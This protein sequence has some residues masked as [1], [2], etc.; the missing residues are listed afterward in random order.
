MDRK[1]SWPC[2]SSSE[3]SGSKVV[4]TILVGNIGV[5]VVIVSGLGTLGHWRDHAGW[6]P[7]Q[8]GQEAWAGSTLGH[9]FGGWLLGQVGQTGL[10]GQSELA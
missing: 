1:G 6:L 5:S 3:F 8:L 2:P 7:L 9:L 10:F 4:S